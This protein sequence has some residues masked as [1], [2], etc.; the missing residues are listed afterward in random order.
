MMETRNNIAIWDNTI[1]S[2]GK[3]IV[4]RSLSAYS[5]V[6]QQFAS[7]ANLQRDCFFFLQLALEQNCGKH[8]KVDMYYVSSLFRMHCSTQNK[9][10]I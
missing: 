7:I 8:T 5:A 4:Y 2:F 10:P 1:L 3:T 6:A 9:H